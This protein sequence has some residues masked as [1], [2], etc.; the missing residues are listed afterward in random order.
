MEQFR[1][2][3]IFRYITIDGDL[4]NVN[5]IGDFN[6]F[7]GRN[8]VWERD[9]GNNWDGYE[10]VDFTPFVG[11]WQGAETNQYA[12]AYLKI[13]T[14]GNWTLTKDDEEIDRG[15]IKFDYEEELDFLVFSDI[16]G[17]ING[18]Y[19]IDSNGD[20]YFSGVGSFIRIS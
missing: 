3:S 18:C 10:F 17:S 20:L 11:L 13:D 15:Y 6:Y 5:T 14:R 8:G 7:D 16:G 12:G 4:I 2:K 9:Y 1:E 19:I